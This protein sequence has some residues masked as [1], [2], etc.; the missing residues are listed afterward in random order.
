MTKTPASAKKMAKQL[1][2][3]HLQHELSSFGTEA[4]IDWFREESDTLFGW[5]RTMP[6]SGFVTAEQVKGVIERNV[7]QHDIPAAVAEIAGEAA[8]H[9]FSDDLQKNTV[10]NEIIDGKRYEEFVDKL[11][12]LHEQRQKGVNHIIDLPIYKDLISGVLYQAIIRYIYESNVITKNIPGVASMLK[13][14]KS[15]V[16]K[17]A[18]SLEGVVEESVRN[19]IAKN[20]GFLI[21]ESKAFLEDSMTDEQLKTSAMDLW[22]LLENKTMADFL[23][24]MDSMDLS[25]LITVGYDFWLQFRKTDY[26]RDSYGLAVDY[27][28]NK[29]G[30]LSLDNLLDDF[31]ITPARAQ[32][33]LTEFA[34]R[35]LQQ[36][37]DSGQLEALLRRRLEAFYL[38]APA[39]ECLSQGA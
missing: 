17:T 28:F 1:L 21:K 26:F 35:I 11:L 6:L 9:L 15:L 3:L 29:Y 19:Y 16:N 38:S 8:A 27:F 22:D 37:R 30:D 33:E 7:V 23:Q 36:L 25:E 31:L 34:P 18:P 20:L 24:G 5:A 14:G 10:V 4:F 13:F 32:A 12:E 39:L 2:E